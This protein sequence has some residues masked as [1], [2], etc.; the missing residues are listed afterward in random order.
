MKR[1]QLSLRLIKCNLLRRALGVKSLL[2]VSLLLFQSFNPEKIS[3]KENINLQQRELSISGVVRDELGDPMPGVNIVV[4]GT[5]NGVITG[6][7][8]NYTI[9]AKTDAILVFSFIGMESQEVRVAGTTTIN[10]TLKTDAIGLDEVIAVGYGVQK[11]ETLTGSIETIAAEVFEDRAVSSPALALQGQ[12]PGLVV[13]RSSS[14]PGSEGVDFQIRGNTSVNGGDPLI[15]IDG[16]PVLNTQ[17][18]YS[19]NSDDIESISV[20]KDGSAAIYGSR[21]ANGVILVT[22][23]NGA[24]NDKM[25]IDV[26][27]TVRYST[28]GIKP[29]S[30]DMKQ[31]ATV[32]LEGLEQDRLAGD[33]GY[34]WKWGESNLEQMKQGYEG[35]Y[36]FTSWGNIYLGDYVN[37]DYLYGSSVSDQHNISI[38]GSTDKVTSRLSIGYIHDRGSLK[39]A[40]D[41]K[42]THNAR[43]NNIFDVCDWFKVKTGVA[44]TKYKI[45]NPSGGYNESNTT[46]QD[47]SFFP[48]VNPYGQWNANF[49]ANGGGI[50]ATAETVD[51]G[52]ETTKRHQVK[53]NIDATAQLTKDLSLRGMAS[54]NAD[55]Y[56]YQKYLLEVATYGWFGTEATSKI[57]STSSITEESETRTYQTYGGFLNYDKKVRDHNFSAMAGV[58]AELY[59]YKLLSGSRTGFDDYGVYDLDMGSSEGEVDN[60]GGAGQYGYVGFVGRFNYNYKDKYLLEL[61]VRRDGSSKFADGYKWETFGGCSLGWILTEESFLNDNPIL[62]YLKLRASYGEMGNNVGI[63]YYDYVSTMAFGTAVFGTTTANEQNTAKVD[64]ITSTTRT[65]ETVSITN[66]GTDFRLFDG[67]VYGSFDYFIKKNDGMLISIDYSSMLGGSAPK[68]NSGLLETKGWEATIGLKKKVTS[69]L[70]VNVSLNISDTRDKLKQMDGATS[71]EYGVNSTVEGYAINSYFLY[72]TDGFFADK[73]EVSAYYD[74]YSSGGE[75]PSQYSTSTTLR[76]GDTRKVDRDGNGII[77]GNGTI[78]EDGKLSGDLKHSGD[79]TPHYTFGIN[80]GANF[81]NFDLSGFFQGVL[82]QNVVRT[83]YFAYPLMRSWTNQTPSYIGKTWTPDNTGAKYPRMTNYT[84][85]SEWNWYNNDFM[86]QNSRYIRLKSLVLGYTLKNLKV[87]RFNVEKLRIYFSGNDL[88]EFTSIKD[89]YDPEYGESSKS[90]YPIMRTWSLG[91]NLTL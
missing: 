35:I 7:D 79:A 73:S 14:Q 13:T 12:T 59:E 64:G 3:A 41:G 24:K 31:F 1:K 51:G 80:L 17:S 72:E 44:Y 20:L 21:A 87:S 81:K 10:V 28:I 18:F 40:Y 6:I 91:L 76:P 2:I 66:M 36:N 50:N 83:G 65:W 56:Q 86:M 37:F 63:G 61:S 8:G 29:V 67:S 53:L 26:N 52:K 22:T 47:P 19:M 74:L 88:F 39:P 54:Y 27:S 43:L 57:N 62:S 82:K 45:L 23:K 11:K 38:S 68:T 4:K 71:I 84:N 9:K 48:A 15:V 85:R 60:S 89:G 70:S 34:T 42:M 78:D 55:F 16:S 5:T 49:G 30:P 46:L 32:W 25:T 90:T 69:D 77:E 33:V 75:A 58:S